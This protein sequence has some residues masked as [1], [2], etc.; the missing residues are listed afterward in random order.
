MTGQKTEMIS[1]F[2]GYTQPIGIVI[3]WHPGKASDN[4]QRQVDYV[5][6]DM[7]QGMNHRR[8]PLE[9]C[10]TSHGGTNCGLAGRPGMV[11]PA[12]SKHP[13]SNIRLCPCQ[14]SAYTPAT[15]AVMAASHSQ[16]KE[17]YAFPGLA[18]RHVILRDRARID[19][20]VHGDSGK[21]M[22]WLKKN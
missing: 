16:C 18:T 11:E 20:I 17:P 7:R 9:R 4:I 5:E 2:L 10:L 6:L 22:A 8:A 3:I 13:P 19:G 15:L 21:M 1:L 14:A 12:T